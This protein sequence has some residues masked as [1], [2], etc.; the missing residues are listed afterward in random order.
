MKCQSCQANIPPE[1]VAAIQKNCCPGCGKDIMNEEMKV[2]LSELTAA[3]EKMPNDNVGLAGWIVSN[4]EL[5]KIGTAEPTQKFHKPI[6]SQKMVKK[7]EELS[8]EEIE[9]IPQ[10]GIVV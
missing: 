6:P 4:Y 8:Q 1:W 10:E 5:R 9:N 3:M 2:L 7:T